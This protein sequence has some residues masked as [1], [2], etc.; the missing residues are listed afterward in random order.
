MKKITN[1]LAVFITV[2]YMNNL[3]EINNEKE[4]KMSY[5]NEIEKFKNYFANKNILVTGGA[6]F[7]GSHLVE[8]LVELGAKVKVLDD[9]STGKLENLK[10]VIDKIEFLRASI[11]DENACIN[12][13]K[14]ISFCFHLA[15]CTS[16]PLC[17]QDP[18]TC[19][20]VNVNGTLNILNACKINNVKVLIFSS[21][22]A[23]Y[24][25]KNEACCENDACEPT[26]FYGISKLMGEM[27]C[28]K[29]KGDKF[30]TIIL[31]YFNVHGPRQE[32]EGQ[33]APV[34]ARFQNLMEKNLPI[35]IF[36]DGKQKRD[37]IHVIDVVN[38]NLKL[39]YLAN[40]LEDNVFNIGT[41]KSINLFEL[42]DQLKLTYPNYNRITEFESSRSGDIYNSVAK[43]DRYKSLIFDNFR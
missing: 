9:L 28:N 32:T 34:V 36:G 20:N 23:V 29:F 42:I 10:T 41:G 17:E 5:T 18:Q 4:D 11:I 39:C 21:S 6:G 2:I 43:C 31:R 12:A 15:A 30:K 8:T 16:V 19:N 13:T 1:Y 38:A 22:A 3:C 35:K 33:F 24:G 25:N 7:I 27:Y 37:F 26:S 40:D 14:N